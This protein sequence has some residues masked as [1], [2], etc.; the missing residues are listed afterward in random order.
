MH[1]KL[2]SFFNILDTKI[3]NSYYKDPAPIWIIDNFLP[4]EIFDAAVNQISNVTNWTE[5]FNENSGSGRKECR[6][7]HEAPLIEA[8]ANAFNSAKAIN[9]LESL[10]E[11]EGLI[12]DPH[13]LGGGLCSILSKSKLDLHTDFNWNNRLKLNR[14][15]N[16]MLYMNK[17][18]HDEWGGALEF[19][20]NDKTECVQKIQPM[21]NRLAVWMYDTNLIHGFP[22]LLNTPETVSRD[23]LIHFYYNSNSTWD[24]DPRRSQFVTN[25]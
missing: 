9:W 25:G 12:P 15:V 23:N 6:N 10:T 13:L 20:D 19:W 5:F 7:L 3:V 17:E 11:T 4:Q 1:D 8:L 14:K 24:A 16:L 21:P 2:Y 18:W 22:E